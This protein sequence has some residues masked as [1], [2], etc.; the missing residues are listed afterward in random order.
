MLKVAVQSAGWYNHEDAVASFEFIKECGF[1]AVDYSIDL[2][3]D[4]DKAN[5]E[6]VHVTKRGAPSIFDKSLE[7]VV[8][9][10]KPLKE[11]SEKTGVSICQMHAPF[12]S[13][14]KDNEPLNKYLSCV[15]DKCLAV[16]EYVGCPAI[17]VH[18][19]YRGTFEL[20]YESNL[21]QYRSL[22]PIVKK[23]KGIKIC[24]ENIFDRMHDVPTKR[25]VEGRLCNSR[26]AV[27]LIDLLNSEAGGEYF[28]FC[29]DV[30]HVNLTRRNVREYIKALG[31]RLTV[32]H[33][34]DND[35]DDDLHTIPY[36]CLDTQTKKPI[37]DWD[38]FVEGLRDVD[39][40][41][42]ICF[43]TF[44]IFHIFPKAVQP[45][46]LKLT[47]TIGRHWAERLEK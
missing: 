40:K 30:G 5:R 2:Y 22:I 19:V 46:A 16:C 42:T 28:G 18:P 34:H 26:D 41:G 45:E 35:G 31:H 6:G 7:E 17:V 1:E 20:E 21:K 4:T 8:E 33:I 12:P 25:I 3:L 11:A 44:R 23:Y 43:E 10:F 14:Y 27:E 47:S 38:N 36:T 13:W 32:L 39:Y 24:L 15:I 29:L 9:F 37:A